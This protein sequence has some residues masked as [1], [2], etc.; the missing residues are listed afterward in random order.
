MKTA[1]EMT[2]TVSGG[3]LNSAQPQPIFY[4]AGPEPRRQENW[5]I[6]KAY[7]LPERNKR[8]YTRNEKVRV[9]LEAGKTKDYK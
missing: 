4:L 7:H 3:V 9:E 2:Y 6:T 5:E 1:S 8:V